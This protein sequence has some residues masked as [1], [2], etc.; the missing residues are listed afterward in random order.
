[1]KIYVLF[2]I[3]FSFGFNSCNAQNNFKEENLIIEFI[4]N[5]YGVLPKSPPPPDVKIDFRFLK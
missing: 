2:F 4:I 3:L 5:K 1:M